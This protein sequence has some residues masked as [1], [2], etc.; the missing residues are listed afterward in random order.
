[1]TRHALGNMIQHFLFPLV[2]GRVIKI[3]PGGYVMQLD[4]KRPARF[5]GE[6]WARKPFTWENVK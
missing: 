4:P 3:L 2:I 6:L 1:M 5:I